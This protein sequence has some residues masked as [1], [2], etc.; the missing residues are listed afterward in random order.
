VRL[1][2][3]IWGESSQ[4]QIVVNTGGQGRGY[5]DG[6]VWKPLMPTARLSGKPEW[7]R[8]VYEIAAELLPK[9]QKAVLIGLGGGDSQ[10]WLSRA[11]VSEGK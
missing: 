9:G 3:D 2:L 10:I 1:E 7:Q 6:G 11:A 5:A 8:F 4:C